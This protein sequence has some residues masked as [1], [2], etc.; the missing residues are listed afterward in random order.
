VVTAHDN[1]RDHGMTVNAFVSV[2][3]DPPLVL[4]SLDHKSSMHRIL[5]GVEKFGISVLTEHQES[6]SNHFAGRTVEG[7]HIPFVRHDGVPLIA[8]AA[9]HFVVRKVQEHPAGDHTLY[10]G[11]VEH[12]ELSDQKPLL[13]YA[14]RYRHLRDD[15][16][17]AHW[18][19]DDFSLFSIGSFD[20]P[21]K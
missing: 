13:F 4:V 2:S 20:P 3:L 6:L 12:F 5:P 11:Q 18:P 17:G 16:T 19:E 7:L 21:V 8:D 15:K 10:I 9:A 1:V 14:G